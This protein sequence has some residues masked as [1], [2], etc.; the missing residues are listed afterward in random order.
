MPKNRTPQTIKSIVRK[1]RGLFLAM[2][3]VL[4]ASIITTFLTGHKV[5]VLRDAVEG[6]DLA[7]KRLQELLQNVLD[8]ETGQ[9]GY[10]LTSSAEYLEPYEATRQSI[11]ANLNA[12]TTEDVSEYLPEDRT[13]EL[14]SLCRQKL[15][16]LQSTIEMASPSEAV[17]TVQ[18]GKGKDIMDAIRMRVSSLQS[19]QENARDQALKDVQRA[20][21]VRTTM[22]VVTAIINLGFLL[23]AFNRIKRE[24]SAQYV[25][26]LEIAKQREILSVT[27][28]SIGDAV[29]ITDTEG[30]IT[31]L[32]K[33]AEDLTGWTLQE[34]ENQPCATV[35]NIIN[36][37]SR[38]PVIS[39]VDKVLAT[40]LIVGLA[41]HTL[42][43][44]RDGIETPI[45]DSGAPIR[46][47]D[48]TIRGVVLVFRDF[49]SHKEAERN[50]IQA[51]EQLEAASHA[52]DK[53]LAT[54]SHELR[55]PLTPVVATLSTW[56]AKHSLPAELEPDL[57]LMRRNVELEAR[58]IDDLLDLTRIEHGKLL[59]EKEAA[60]THGLLDAVVKLYKADCETKKVT[61]SCRYQATE[62]FV[63]ADPARLQ[64]VFWNLVGN[65]IK[66]TA[67]GGAIEIITAN[68]EANLLEITIADNGIGMSPETLGQLFQRF[69]QGD[70]SPDQKSRGLGLGLSIARALVDSHD[71]ALTASSKGPGEGSIFTIKLPTVP[72]PPA[73]PNL[74]G[75]HSAPTQRSLQ[76]L[77]LEDHEDTA[78]VLAQIIRGMGHHVAVSHTVAQANKLIHEETFDL[79]LSDIG[80]PDGTGVDFI[81]EARKVCD[82]PAI[83]L[84]GYG[85]AE[86]IDRCLSAGFNDHLTKPIDFERLQRTLDLAAK[87]GLDA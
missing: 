22:F 67:P 5:M 83:A 62:E 32:N 35:F 65:A 8:A 27:L 33:I 60:S 45:D 10:L 16:E 77:L 29:I 34:A 70:L 79:I 24:M 14:A 68:P 57:Q 18:S 43:I 6:R 55:T 71:G 13:A 39:P 44:R 26:A 52:K 31:F 41:N 63:L 86:D 50:L 49:T 81:K 37:Y 30:K 84:T 17:Q 48:G 73:T 72:P 2:A 51:K 25:I 53:F 11:S 3:I 38:E 66:F 1:L 47:A 74:S 54:L 23:W 59:L 12:L 56:E 9:R 64:Q 4:I 82:T 28:A 20:T 36:E 46:E 61:L 69:H 42:L 75:A 85:M 15:S 58:L 21:L 80:L 78:T 19:E 7:I 40:G 87:H 76:V